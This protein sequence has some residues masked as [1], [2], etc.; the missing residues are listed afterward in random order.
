MDQVKTIFFIFL[1]T[2]SNV[3]ETYADVP[4]LIDFK[5]DPSEDIAI[6]PA[7]SDLF[8][9]VKYSN[10]F[11]AGGNGLS[12]YYYDLA[13]LLEENYRNDHSG[14]PNLAA[15]SYYKIT[16][17]L[18]QVN[19]DKSIHLYTKLI[20]DDDLEKPEQTD[21]FITGTTIR[22]E[23]SFSREV[24]HINSCVQNHTAVRGWVRP[25]NDH[26]LN[27]LLNLFPGGW[28]LDKFTL[29]DGLSAYKTRHGNGPPVHTFAKPGKCKE[30][31]F[32]SITNSGNIYIKW[33][34]DLVNQI[35][36]LM[37]FLAN[38]FTFSAAE[39][40]FRGEIILAGIKI[41]Y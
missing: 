15:A 39:A 18:C 21:I 33:E 10:L 20:C 27:S 25:V 29:N 35:G 8:S 31:G 13:H 9:K 7:K 26:S 6:K 1:I 19:F 37:L 24:Q 2:V 36:Q 40:N 30:K 5:K 4:I 11:P 16:R 14:D 28:P 22:N 34:C 3:P 38:D 17:L 23:Q 12:P 32:S 41:I